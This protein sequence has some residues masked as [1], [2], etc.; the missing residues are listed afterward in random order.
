MDA[1]VRGGDSCFGKWICVAS[2]MDD[3]DTISWPV[4]GSA[5]CMIEV[6]AGGDNVCEKLSFF[7]DGFSSSGVALADCGVVNGMLS[8]CA[9]FMTTG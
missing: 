9:G 2:V 5:T 3:D 6:F 7:G 8:A 1:R 4:V